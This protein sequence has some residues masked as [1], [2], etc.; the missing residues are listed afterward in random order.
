[1]SS[2]PWFDAL[3]GFRE[4][5]SMDE[6]RAKFDVE[7]DATGRGTLISKAN[8]KRYGAGRFSTPSLAELRADVKRAD[9]PR[10]GTLKLSHIASSDVFALHADEE[11]SGAFFQA[12][13]QF[14]CL[15]FASPYA[16]PEDGVTIYEHDKTQGP[17]C[18]LA[19]P[20]ATV[21]RNYFVPCKGATGQSR[22]KQL[23]LLGDVLREVQGSDG[24]AAGDLVEVRNGYTNSDEEEL[25]QFN[26]KLRAVADRD[27]LAGLLRIGLHEDV[28]VPWTGTRYQ[29]QQESD[30]Q[31]VSQA[32]CSALAVGYSQGSVEGWEPLARLVLEASYEATLWA[33]ARQAANGGSPKVVLT[34]L[35]GGVFGN[36][37]E[38]ILSAIARACVRLEGHGLDVIVV[39]FRM[40][41]Q[42]LV[43]QLDAAM[44][45]EKKKAAEGGKL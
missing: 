41:N 36:A 23:N 5:S 21:F 1:M 42:Q 39:H 13:S 3:F 26:D 35:G 11:F 18:S 16:T 7:D 28:E 33:G 9:K 38:W 8:G 45:E 4:P 24:E 44:E 12:A 30:R 6:C 10:T 22:D 29:L 40:V 43:D 2:G 25:Q 14:N 17:A 32:F 15:E 34:L 37:P 20:A 31:K 19:A 27:K